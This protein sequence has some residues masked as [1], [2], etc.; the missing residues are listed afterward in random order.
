MLANGRFDPLDREASLPEIRSRLRRL[1]FVT[2]L[3]DHEAGHEDQ[4]EDN[5]PDCPDDRRQ[6]AD[7]RGNRIRAP[8]ARI[9]GTQIPT[10][11]PASLSTKN[12]R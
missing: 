10:K 12:Q 4:G 2:L 8:K 6:V 11:T 5:N 7:Q 9:D 1:A 3:H